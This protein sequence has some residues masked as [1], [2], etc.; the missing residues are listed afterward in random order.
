MANQRGWR[1]HVPPKTGYIAYKI[2]RCPAVRLRPLVIIGD[3]VRYRGI[4]WAGGR[5]K[6]CE[7]TTAC[8]DCEHLNK[9]REQAEYC[10]AC[11][12]CAH[13]RKQLPTYKGYLAV[14]N[15]DTG[16]KYVLEVT[17]PT[18]ETFAAYKRL[19]GTLRGATVTLKR[20]GIKPNGRMTAEIQPS[21]IPATQLPETFPVE[22]VMDEMWAMP[23]NPKNKGMSEVRD[24]MA[25]KSAAEQLLDELFKK[26]LINS[27]GEIIPTTAGTPPT[28]QTQLPHETQAKPEHQP[29]PDRTPE[30]QARLDK[31]KAGVDKKAA[32]RKAKE[33]AEQLPKISPIIEL[34]DAQKARLAHNKAAKKPHPKGENE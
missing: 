19:Y 14:C 10:G 28:P 15:P 27:K 1:D 6:P 16:E 4:H 29:K 24:D 17:P 33:A 32:A 18:F 11:E 34:T 8:K 25:G 31:F 3:N 7:G 26:G 12:T 22:P 21:G 2:L 23:N 30:Q 13:C 20:A 5:S 9:Q